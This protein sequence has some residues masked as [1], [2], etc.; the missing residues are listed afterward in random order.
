MSAG[1]SPRIYSPAP[2]AVSMN[3]CNIHTHTDAE[4]ECPDFSLFGR[5]GERGGYKC[6][7][8]PLLSADELE[9]PEP[10]HGAFHGVKPG[11]SLKVSSVYSTCEVFPG[12]GLVSCVR[13]N[14]DNPQLRVEAQNFLLVDARSAHQLP[15]YGSPRSTD[16]LDATGD[17]ISRRPVRLPC[18]SP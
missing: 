12:Q 15:E 11:E 10:G 3:L 9:Y 16:A 18:P 4:H 17:A 1:Q 8:T 2:F 14:C 7:E 13:S 5:D 6:N